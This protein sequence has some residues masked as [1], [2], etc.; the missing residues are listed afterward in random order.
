MIYND[1][2]ILIIVFVKAVALI[3]GLVMGLCLSSMGGEGVDVNTLNKVCKELTDDPHSY[4]VGGR[5]IQQEFPCRT[6]D[7]IKIFEDVYYD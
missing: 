5:G 2:L 1:T 7:T 4:F 6:N 3:I